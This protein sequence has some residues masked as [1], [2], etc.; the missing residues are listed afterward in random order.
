MLH[1]TL[2]QL[3]V[4]ESAARHLSFSRAAKELHLSQPGVSMQIKQLEEALGRPLFEQLGKRLFL[5]EVGREV[6]RASQSVAQQLVDLEDTLNDLRGLKQGALTVGVVSTVSHF[7]IRLISQFRHE[8][9]EVRITLNVVN[10][11]QLLDQ[12]ANNQVDLALM[13]Q[14]PADQDLESTPFMENPLVVIAPL[15]HPLAQQKDIPLARITEED[16]VARETGSGTRSAT[17]AFFQSHGLTLR[18]AMEM[19]KN[20]AIKQAVE[21]GLGLGVVSRHT[22]I[23][24]LAAR[25]LV[26]LD[27]EGFPI[28]RQWHLV[29]RRNKHFSLAASAF[30]K[31]VLTRANR[32]A[33]FV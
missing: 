5:T 14:P 2:R 29:H 6:L 4:F 16:F 9:P 33:G 30:A 24:E 3:Q 26:T 25:R 8:H 27:V 23:L 19:N 21:A 15:G 18:A 28:R 31:F 10:R 20:E 12:L 11:E 17:E 1:L 7:A 32:A 13:G 22:V